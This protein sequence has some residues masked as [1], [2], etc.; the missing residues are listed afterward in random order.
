MGNASSKS[1]RAA[2][3]MSVGT[4]V[5][6]VLSVT[7]L[8][9]GL[10][11]VRQI[12]STGTGAINGID[13]EVQNQIQ[14]LFDEEGSRLAMFPASRRVS[15]DQGDSDKGFA[16][17]I[18]NKDSTS[19]A[20]TYEVTASDIGNCEGLTTEDASSWVL[21]GSGETGTIR[22]GDVFG[23]HLVTFTIPETA[24]LCTIEYMIN[25][26]RSS[27]EVYRNLNFFLKVK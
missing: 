17:A 3:E 13:A 11:L 19:S 6:I 25:V 9:L 15:L 20:F 16:F 5:T 7:V 22:S 4:I 8:V 23:P 24:P 21:G 26:E 12:F 18:N 10:V 14:K 1:K 2:M 27:G